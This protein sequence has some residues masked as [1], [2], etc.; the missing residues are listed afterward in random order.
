MS[1]RNLRLWENNMA[2]GNMLKEAQ[3]EAT[4][5]DFRISEI[6]TMYGMNRF[7]SHYVF[8]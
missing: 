7:Y 8:L 4:T 1:A 5:T 2:D 3:A 6:H